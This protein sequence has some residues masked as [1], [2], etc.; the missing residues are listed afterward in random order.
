MDIKYDGLENALSRKGVRGQS[1][2]GSNSYNPTG[3]V[4]DGHLRAIFNSE[5]IGRTAVGRVVDDA[6]RKGF[7]CDN[8]T[9]MDQF[10]DLKGAQKF[11]EAQLWGR[12]FGGALIVM[13]IDDGS[14][15]L[16]E[17]LNPKRVTAVRSMQVY[18]RT[19]VSIMSIDNNPMSDNFDKPIIYNVSAQTSFS[20]HYTRCIRFDGITTD[21][22]TRE[23]LNGWDN[24]ALQPVYSK[25]MSYFSNLASGEQILDEFIIGVLS[26]KNLMD[27]SKTE[28]GEALIKK[29]LAILDQTKSNENTVIIDGT[30]EDYTKHISSLSGYN[31][32]VGKSEISVASSCVPVMPATV[33]YGVSP[34]GENATGESDL[35]LW[36]DAVGSYQQSDVLPK[37]KEFFDILDRDSNYTIEFN[38]IYEPNIIEQSTAF[39]NFMSG[40]KSA[41]DGGI[42]SPE[43]IATSLEGI[44]LIHDR[45]TSE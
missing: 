45:D 16:T 36:Y 26:M 9:L 1:K 43:E 27:L 6:Y 22:R 35:R 14:E 42:Y 12:L 32:V 5:G 41:V 13:I 19:Q 23:T 4:T 44:N 38:K 30:D 15:D 28:S 7:V 24:S 21:W 29:R 10:N 31:D 17:P 33:L 18:D 37:L 25:L 20:I 2:Q 39:N 40:G 3:F 11:R 8:D 34:T